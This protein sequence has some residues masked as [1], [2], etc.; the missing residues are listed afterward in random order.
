[1]SSSAWSPKEVELIVDDYFSMLASELAGTPYSK[2][3]HREKLIPLLS[4]R[5]PQSIE[6][7]H[8]NISA[9]LLHSG[10]PYINGYKPRANY[11]ALLAATVRERLSE[12][13]VLLDLAASDADR[14]MVVPEVDD[15]LSVLV[16]RASLKIKVTKVREVAPRLSRGLPTNYLEREAC[17]RS[18]GLAG[19]LFVL[20]YE[21]ARLIHAK[22]E[23]LAAQ[24]EHTSV[25]RGDG[26]GFDI[27]SFEQNGAE[28]MIEVKT[29]KYGSETPFFVTRNELGVSKINAPQY[30]L[31]RLF[32]FRE[33]PRLF[34]LAGAIDATCELAAA[35]FL[36]R[37]K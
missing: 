1:M 25:V 13:P 32:T 20:N 21:R 18:L 7:K 17:N 31:Y 23:A 3:A 35:S 5:S 36:A 4:G 9:A 6:F 12:K 14:P 19:E 15:I 33:T 10:F 26:D 16:K 27:L 8:A 22:K 2:T 29:T 30:Q 24:I 28:R 11:Q 37:P 34:M